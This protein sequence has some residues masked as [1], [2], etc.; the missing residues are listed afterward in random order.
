LDGLRP[1]AGDC[2]CM[3]RS[4]SA[5]DLRANNILACEEVEE[6]DLR[7]FGAAFAVGDLDSGFTMILS[8]NVTVVSRAWTVSIA[9]ELVVVVVTLAASVATGAVSA[10]ATA[11]AVGFGVDLPEPVPRKATLL[12]PFTVLLAMGLWLF[13]PEEPPWLWL[14]L[15]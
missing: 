15:W 5:E 7:T 3:C 1:R 10:V 13:A 6:G 4:R 2:A 11:S 14:L 12:P 9:S 8:A